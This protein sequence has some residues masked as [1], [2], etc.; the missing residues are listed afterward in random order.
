M[1]ISGSLFVSKTPVEYA[2]DLKEAGVDYFHLD[3]AE[4]EKNKLSRFEKINDFDEF[5]IPLDVHLICSKV[6]KKVIKKLNNSKTEILS[7]QYE[8]LIDANETIENLREFKKGFGLAVSPNTNLELILPYT[9]LINHILLMCSTPGVSGAKFLEN[10]FSTI[11]QIRKQFPNI[12]IYV[13]GGINNDI[14]DTM[15]VKD[16]SLS[17]FGSYLY[18]NIDNLQQTITRLKK[19]LIKT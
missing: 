11:E 8:N 5:D 6:N 3:F 13:D 15:R 19:P 2:R 7:V 16:V 1:K 4:K 14:C 10:S 9:H 12:P 18:N 17:V